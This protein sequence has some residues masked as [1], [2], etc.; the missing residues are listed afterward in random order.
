MPGTERKHAKAMC[1]FHPAIPGELRVR[2]PRKDPVETPSL[3]PKPRDRSVRTTAVG[4]SRDPS[5]TGHTLGGPWAWHFDVESLEQ[6]RD[7]AEFLRPL[8]MRDRRMKQPRGTLTTIAEELDAAA[9][10]Q[11]YVEGA[12]DR[13][14]V[15]RFERDPKARQRYIQSGKVRPR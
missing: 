12:V 14:V 11:D 6:A 7:G 10:P 8:A 5:K 9:K 4:S 13:I 15:N 3:V 2:L 1:A